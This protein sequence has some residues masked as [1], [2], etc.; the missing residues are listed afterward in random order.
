[1]PTL[2]RLRSSEA[3][4]LLGH[5]LALAAVSIARFAV[6]VKWLLSGADGAFATFSQYPGVHF[7]DPRSIISISPYFGFGSNFAGPNPF[8]DP[9]GLLIHATGSVVIPYVVFALIFFVSVYAL[10]RSLDG[11]TALALASSWLIVVLLFPLGHGVRSMVDIAPL[12]HPSSIFMIAIFCFSVALFIHVGQ[13]VHLL[14]NAISAVGF[15]LLMVASWINNLTFMALTLPVLAVVLGVVALTSVT[16]REFVWKLMSIAVVFALFKLLAVDSYLDSFT[17]YSRRLAS[18]QGNV[19]GFS[20]AARTY[21]LNL[22]A[23]TYYRS[24]HIL[25]GAPILGW[26]GIAGLVHGALM[27]NRRWRALCLAGLACIC[28]LTLVSTEFD[29]PGI[30]W[31]WAEPA[32]FEWPLLPFYAIGGVLA[33]GQCVEFGLRFVEKRTQRISWLLLRPTLIV[34]LAVT[35]FATVSI[36]GTLTNL[37]TAALAARVASPPKTWPQADS[38]WPAVA[39]LVN[40]E[41]GK[42]FAGW[43]LDLSPNSYGSSGNAVLL[44][45]VD[46]WR[47]GGGTLF[48]MGPEVNLQM[49]ALERLR[50]QVPLDR[51]IAWLGAYGLAY[52]RLSP[53]S[54]AG[55]EILENPMDNVLPGLRQVRYSNLGR[56]T[57]TNVVEVNNFADFSS[58]VIS[59]TIDWRKTVFLD[60]EAAKVLGSNDLVSAKFVNTPLVV[61]NGL[62]IT[63]E[64][65]GKSLLILPRQF[66]NCYIWRPAVGSNGEVSVV[67]ANMLQLAILFRG[68]ISGTLEFHYPWGGDPECRA[69]DPVDARSLGITPPQIE[70]RH[71]GPIGYY[72]LLRAQQHALA[73]TIARA[74]GAEL[75]SMSEQ[76]LSAL[77]ALVVEVITASGY[78]G[79]ALLMGIES[80]CIPVPSEIIMPFAGYLASTGRFSLLMAATMGALGCNV[81]STVAYFVAA[82]GG[83]KTLEH[84]GHYILI[85]P[86]DIRQAD[87]FF[88]TYGS[89][90]VFVGRL[91]PIIRT[92]IAFPAGLARMPMLKFQVYTFLGSWPWCFGLAY[93]GYVL[94]QRWN[95][96][97]EFHKWFHEFDA[98]VVIVLLMGA[99]WFLWSHRALPGRPDDFGDAG[100]GRGKGTKMEK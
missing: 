64:T 16:W 7:T 44:N 68:S 36:G 39:N 67:R 19:E 88:A 78:L 24:N 57:P 79:V 11:G 98:A 43:F 25:Y 89:A 62:K 73:R 41:Q 84:W 58:H 23:N 85:R 26:L 59:D 45:N 33:F 13:Q 69:R 81:G 52:V 4:C 30:I 10:V 46:I 75:P 91:L 35:C 56:F 22:V 20:P 49:D 90:A 74:G 77:G 21:L 97:P 38:R 92:F 93:V 100:R 40:V 12:G 66:S 47:S 28:G 27:G 54:A 83:R 95:S 63:A 53:A 37:S 55:T 18:L 34:G 50:G 31:P 94:G 2:P 61:T 80:A 65:L 1:M 17:S 9:L 87:A 71:F 6:N 3:L 72:V 51:Q 15:A 76:L 48:E 29:S 86:A 96:D 70:N 42:A 99:A 82:K 8:T 32:Y 14:Y 60:H 5:L